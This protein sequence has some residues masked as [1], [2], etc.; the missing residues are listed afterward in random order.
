[1]RDESRR[2]LLS[3]PHAGER[4]ETVSK[5][6]NINKE[7]PALY[8]PDVNIYLLSDICLTHGRDK[9]C[10]GG[11]DE[12]GLHTHEDTDVRMR[13]H[14]GDEF[15]LGEECRASETY[16]ASDDTRQKRQG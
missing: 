3:R 1:M 13:G 11:G 15:A 2:I 12:S 16:V 14:E 7:S 5:H 8:I 9:I 6:L 10:L 4:E